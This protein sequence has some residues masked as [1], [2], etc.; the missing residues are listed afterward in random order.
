MGGGEGEGSRGFIT[1]G[2]EAPRAK[3]TNGNR[4]P[5][6]TP[7][8]G[9][10]LSISVGGPGFRPSSD[11]GTVTWP[12]SNEALLHASVP[13]VLCSPPRESS[14]SCFRRRPA[15]RVTRVGVTLPPRKAR[16]ARDHDLQDENSWFA[17]SSQRF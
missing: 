9:M 6:A 5:G 8:I 15:S 2:G 4:W 13:L 17:G 7:S 3:H 1:K 14:F 16:K 11:S 12:R 10:Q